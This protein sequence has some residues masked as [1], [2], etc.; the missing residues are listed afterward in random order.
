MARTFLRYEPHLAYLGRNLALS[1]LKAFE[2]DKLI[3][4]QFL[5]DIVENIARKKVENAGYQ[6]FLHFSQ[7]FPKADASGSLKAGVVW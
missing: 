3:D 6:H 7:C 2:D 1:K 4:S 5:L